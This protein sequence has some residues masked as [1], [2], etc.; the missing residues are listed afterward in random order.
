VLEQMHAESGHSRTEALTTT[1]ALD[2]AAFG[3]KQE[4]KRSLSLL[5]LLTYG[6]VFI[7]PISPVA[8]FGIVFNAS[9]GMV[10]LV[11]LVG[12]G[13][14]IFTA[15]S[16]VAMSR[17]FPVAGSVY[18][19]ASCSL[20]RTVGFIGGWAILLDYLLMPT[21]IYVGTAIAVHSA[22]PLISG[23]LC[24]VIMLATT[25]IINYLGIETTVRASFVL[26]AF[27]L[28][29]I[30]LFVGLSMHA[31]MH[32]V[33]GAHLSLAPFYNPAEFTPRLIFGAL[34]L[35]VLS[36]LGFDAISTLSEESKDG[37]AAVGRATILSLCVA[38]G[39]FLVQ[40]WLGS[41]FVLGK[42]SLPAGDATNAAFYDIADL[43][44]GYSYKFLLA[45]PGLFLSSVAGAVT[46]QAATARLLFGMSRDGE[47]PR[48]LAYVD[49]RRKV[50]VRA[51]FLVAIFTLVAALLLVNRLELLTGMVSFGALLGFLLVHLSVI[52]H[53]NF[54]KKSGNWLFHVVVPGAGLIVIG[55][56]IFSA[57]ISAKIAGATWLVIGLIIWFTLRPTHSIREGSH[58]AIDAKK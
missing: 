20:G 32:H 34:S 16:Y 51:V 58:G 55:Y 46:A 40:A 18:T 43:V 44:G 4:L 54:R 12:L 45:V 50:P 42:T 3:Y 31:L 11:Y 53:F 38:A 9:H 22:L 14:M 15:L 6:L 2:I 39:L 37:A 48:A 13:A 25:T 10:P 33:A 41:L 19:Y 8:L 30:L 1:T 56:V 27:Q 7:V 57:Q 17:E 36:F 28:F 23:P 24:I 21:I 29:L 47:L 5:D 52:V 49:S 35:A 26:L